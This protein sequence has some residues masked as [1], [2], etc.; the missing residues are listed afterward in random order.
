MDVHDP[1]GDRDT[2]LMAVVFRTA[3]LEDLEAVVALE[4]ANYPLDEVVTPQKLRYRLDHAPEFFL[5]GTTDGVV[6][7]FICGTLTRGATLTHH[8]MDVQ[9]PAGDHLCIHSVVVAPN[10]RRQGLAAA[11]LRE[12]LTLARGRLPPLRRVSL[13]AK[14]PLRPLYE[15][16]GFKLVGPSS[17]VLGQDPWLDFTLDLT[18]SP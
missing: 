18:P 11:L 12:Y 6:V 16:A 4:A 13:I 2:L 8:S 1:A 7:A 15:A 14:A 9:D 17:V 10:R 5:V 3:T